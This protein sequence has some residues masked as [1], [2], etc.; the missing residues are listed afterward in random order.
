MLYHSREPLDDRKP[1]TS[2]Q[3]SGY[4]RG[5]Y[6]N[7]LDPTFTLTYTCL[8]AVLVMVRVAVFAEADKQRTIQTFR[9]PAET[10]MH[11]NPFGVAIPRHLP[12]VI[13][14]R[15]L[16]ALEISHIVPFGRSFSNE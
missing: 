8:I 15:L 2:W 3:E 1:V 5:Q 9:V 12:P 10:L 11:V 6:S 14:T 13:L 16:T 4:G 7:W